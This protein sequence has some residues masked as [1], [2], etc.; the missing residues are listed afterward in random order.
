LPHFLTRE[1][2]VDHLQAYA[3]A[4][5][6]NLITS[7]QIQSTVYYPESTGSKDGKRR[8]MVKFNT[9]TGVKTVFSNHLVQATGIGSRKPFV[10]VVPDADLYQGI[11]LHS[12]AYNDTTQF[13]ERGAKSVLVVGS[14][15]TGFDITEDCYAA[16]LQTTMV[17]RSATWLFPVRYICQGLAAYETMPIGAADETL[18]TMPVSVESGLVKSLFSHL[19]SEEPYVFFFSLFIAFSHLL[20]LPPILHHNCS[21]SLICILFPN[22]HPLPRVLFRCVSAPHHTF[23]PPIPPLRQICTATTQNQ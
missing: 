23:P 6:V 8:W 13:T 20:I 7:A 12:S 18:M 1:N 15:N 3:E 11:N 22:K 14:A 21:F 4:F 9:P 17:A 16:G 10:P 5:K 19:A 2:L